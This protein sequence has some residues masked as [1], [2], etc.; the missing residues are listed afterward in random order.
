[1]ANAPRSAIARRASNIPKPLPA[2]PRPTGKLDATTLAPSGTPSRIP[3]TPASRRLLNIAPATV[4]A[5]PRFSLHAHSALENS[6]DVCISPKKSVI[7]ESITASKPRE[8]MQLKKPAGVSAKASDTVSG[9]HVGV[10]SPVKITETIDLEDPFA[11]PQRK[12]PAPW[13]FK[14]PKGMPTFPKIPTHNPPMTAGKKRKEIDSAPVTKLKAMP[15]V[16]CHAPGSTPAKKG[17][18]VESASTEEKPDDA[19]SSAP[20]QKVVSTEKLEVPG[21]EVDIKVNTETEAPEAKPEDSLD[22]IPEDEGGQPPA[23]KRLRFDEGIK[24]MAKKVVGKGKALMDKSRLDF[25]ATPKR[26]AEKT[27]AAQIAKA[28]GKKPSWK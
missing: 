17:K 27:V 3:T 25:L 1:M 5:A 24:E 28:A 14:S 4:G 16:P 13:G 12:V 6:S 26:K 19:L 23:K 15:S 20:G 9:S 21:D 22:S 11:T 7:G 8:I 10:L 2:L 18:Y